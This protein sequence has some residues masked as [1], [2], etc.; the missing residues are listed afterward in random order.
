MVVS[1]W[2][3]A[4]PMYRK[5]HHYGTVVGYYREARSI[6]TQ[7]E[8][9]TFEDPIR[10]ARRSLKPAGNTSR[11]QLLLALSHYTHYSSFL[12]LLPPHNWQETVVI[13]VPETQA[14]K[15]TDILPGRGQLW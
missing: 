1:W 3:R 9:K 12:T 8:L 10:P 14:L 6:E 15:S 4:P 7:S 13:I 11:Q 2:W 5:K